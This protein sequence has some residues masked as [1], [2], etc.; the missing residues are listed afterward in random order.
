MKCRGCGHELDPM[1]YEKCPR[2]GSELGWLG[3]LIAARNVIKAA[4]A[5][6]GFFYLLSW[7]I[8]KLTR[9]F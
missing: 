5:I 2:C 4:F 9:L 1:F 3:N 7:L 8:N 6:L